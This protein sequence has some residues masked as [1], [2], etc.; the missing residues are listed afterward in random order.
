MIF[1]SEHMCTV[2]AFIPQF[3]YAFLIQVDKVCPCC[4]S[5]LAEYGLGNQDKAKTTQTQISS[6]K[7]KLKL[8]AM[9]VDSVR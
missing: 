1:I 6:K 8:Y 5:S 9:L 3:Y 4:G 7:K 2:P